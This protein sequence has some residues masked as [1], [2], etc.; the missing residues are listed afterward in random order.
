MKC[1]YCQS[2]TNLHT[3]HLIPRSRG[4]RNVEGN[5][6]RACRLCNTS[7][8]NRLPSEWRKDLPPEIY[9]LEKAALKLHPMIKARKSD[10]FT[11]KDTCINVRCT[12]EQ[13]SKIETIA[14]SQGLGASTWLLSLGLRVERGAQMVEGRADFERLKAKYEPR[15]L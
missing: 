11:P 2:T 1:L 10:R 7:K 4:G 15:L 3:E 12:K 5:L 8:G 6:F 9:E 13:K 14:W